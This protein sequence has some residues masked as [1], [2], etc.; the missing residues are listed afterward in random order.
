MH[1]SQ[2][3]ICKHRMLL[4]QHSHT[5]RKPTTQSDRQGSHEKPRTLSAC[6]TA[7]IRSKLLRRHQALRTASWPLSFPP[8]MRCQHIEDGNLH[9][10][11]TRETC[12][13]VCGL[14]MGKLAFPSACSIII[15]ESNAYQAQ[16]GML[17]QSLEAESRHHIRRHVRRLG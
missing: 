6:S 2:Q 15:A 14:Y 17:R 12:S 3:T 4:Y 1:C 10:T 16:T 13:C 9:A 5:S 11:I 8:S 7:K